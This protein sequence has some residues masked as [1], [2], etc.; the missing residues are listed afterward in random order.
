MKTH[1]GRDRAARS[2]QLTALRAGGLLALALLR[3]IQVV[4]LLREWAGIGGKNLDE[5]AP[6]WKNAFFMQLVAGES[7]HVHL[8]FLYEPDMDC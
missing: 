7:A 2:D 6:D 5:L 4:R 1:W 3:G 8:L